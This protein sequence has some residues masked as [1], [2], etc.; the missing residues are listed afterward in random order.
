MAVYGVAPRAKMNQQRSRGFRTSKDAK[1]IREKAES[2]GEKLPDEKAFDSN[3]IMPGVFCVVSHAIIAV[4]VS[5]Q[6]RYFVDKKITEDANWRGVQVVLSGHEVPGEERVIDDFIPLAVFVGNDFLPNLPDLHIRENGLDERLFDV[7]KKV[8]PSQ[9]RPGRNDY[10][11]ERSLRKN[12]Q[13]RIGSRESGANTSRRW[14][15]RARAFLR[16][17]NET[18]SMKPSMR[19]SGKTDEEDEEARVAVDRVL[20]KFVWQ[21]G[22]TYEDAPLVRPEPFQNF[23]PPPKVDRPGLARSTGIAEQT[24]LIVSSV[25]IRAGRS[26][27]LQTSD[28]RST[29]LAGKRKRDDND[30]DL[31]SNAFNVETKRRV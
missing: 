4:R 21:T 6:L 26:R 28:S 17:L 11:S 18:F 30:D 1:E 16:T 19:A 5:A 13:T 29:A 12:T 3:S 7:Y 22:F 27:A 25:A 20:K 8:L 9:G 10:G 15:L 23:N 14:N 31:S 24:E 2:K